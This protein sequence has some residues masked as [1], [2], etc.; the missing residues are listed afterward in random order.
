MSDVWNNIN[1]YIKTGAKIS[2]DTKKVRKINKIDCDGMVIHLRHR[3][4]C[5]DMDKL[6]SVGLDKKLFKYFTIST[7]TIQYIK[8]TACYKKD[9]RRKQ[10]IFPRFGIIELLSGWKNYVVKNHI[11]V[12]YSPITPYKWT[13]KYKD[14]QPIIINHILTKFF[15]KKRADAGK[16]GVLLN[17][18]AGQ[19]KSY[20]AT[21]LIQSLKVKTLVVCHNKNILYQW[22]DILQKAYPSNTIGQY[23]GTTKV[24]GDIVV[25]VINSLIQDTMFCDANMPITPKEFFKPFGFVILDEVHEY[26]SKTRSIIYQKA[27]STYMLG[28]SATPDE[29]I[30]GLDVI[31]IWNV[32]QMLKAD[33]LPGYTME[34]ITFQGEV[35][36]IKY[37]GPI[38]YTKVIVNEALELVSVPK[39]IT[40]LMGDPY[41]IYLIVKTVSS[42]I[43]DQNIFVFADRREYLERIRVELQLYNIANDIVDTDE[44]VARLV[45]GATSNEVASAENKATVILT[46][47]Q[48]MGTGKSIP[49]M[50]AAIL[51][52][53]RRRKSKQY[54]GRIFR[55]GSNYNKMRKIIDIVDW[56]T[57]MK[58]QWYERK[59]Y[60]DS[61]EFPIT[62]TLVKYT[63]LMPEMKNMGLIADADADE[64]SSDESVNGLDD[65]V[66]DESNT[67][68][69][70]T[71]VDID[72][73][74]D[75]DNLDSE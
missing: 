55:A 50:D 75:I 70:D 52:T 3:G 16:S 58:A 66:I 9:R 74:S 6:E 46:T 19:G 2:T 22:V 33:E 71:L 63:E 32:G 15:N 45:G 68:D 20:I 48:F 64:L 49:K 72:T 35:S 29:R 42:M 10:V 65:L 57:P 4:A 8:L 14:N 69:I 27:Q 36:M 53:P 24:D 11:Y 7:K 21:G 62:Q 39:M 56:G 25:G 13:G 67:D 44:Q 51:A 73:L 43:D 5:I 28:L 41:R 54:I 31:N 37:V 47:Y 26:C 40:Q 18:D 1:T 34:N 17:L 61:K 38:E 60:Y 30:D 23:Y 12:G 59:L